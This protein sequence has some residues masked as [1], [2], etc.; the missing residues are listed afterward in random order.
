MLR[1]LPGIVLV[2]LATIAL[3]WVNQNATAQ[4]ILL[5][6]ALPSVI[7]ACV[8]AFWFSAISRSHAEQRLGV[9]RE[10]HAADRE[11]LNRQVE[12]TRSDVL[13]KASA[14]QAKI[15]ERAHSDREK[16]VRKTHKEVLR[17]ER[18]ASRR[19]S[20]KVGIAFMFMTALGIVFLISELLT[21]GLMTIMTAGGALGG[22]M[23][24]WRQSRQGTALPDS[25]TMA[26]LPELSDVVPDSKDPVLIAERKTLPNPAHKGSLDAALMEEPGRQKRSSG[27]FGRR[28]TT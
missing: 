28:D 27:F 25:E 2:Q 24:R 26:Q 23:L 18:S 22:Y 14:D 13:Q 6:V 19:A 20:L 4:E 17:S 1:F 10:K 12:R 15:I 8:T 16:L 21:L 5:R 7:F 9:L 11:D 3:F